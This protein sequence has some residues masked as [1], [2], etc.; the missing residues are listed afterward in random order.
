VRE[1]WL[2]V[3]VSPAGVA[4]GR[5]A[6]APQP[7]SPTSGAEVVRVERSGGLAGM[8]LAADVALAGLEPSEA[9]AWRHLLGSDRLRGLAEEPPQP[10]RYVYRL[11]CRPHDLDVTA[12]EQQ[13]PPDVLAL[14]ERALRG[15]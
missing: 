1:A 2:A 7:R 8:V 5:A 6:A 9:A 11:R 13:L 4:A 15:A 10:D 14:I 3:G 12:A